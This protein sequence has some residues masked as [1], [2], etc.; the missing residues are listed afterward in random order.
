M[1]K[2]WFSFSYWQKIAIQLISCYIIWLYSTIYGNV[3]ANTL[4]W[5]HLWV[6][7]STSATIVL[8]SAI[9]IRYHR[10]QNVW[11]FNIHH[12]RIK[13]FIWSPT[14]ELVCIWAKWFFRSLATWE[15]LSHWKF[16]LLTL[17]S[18]SDFE[19]WLL[20][21]KSRNEVLDKPNNFVHKSYYNR[22]LI[23]FGS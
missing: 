6:W 3:F 4:F 16:A 1:L 5:K 8:L 19:N 14:F 22:S 13:P 2:L 20:Q 17:F 10:I 12:W 18:L 21:S 9:H 15:D 23:P 7:T 11:W